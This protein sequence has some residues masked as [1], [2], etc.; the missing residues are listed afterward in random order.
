M[1]V[2]VELVEGV[3]VD[4]EAPRV[5]ADVGQGGL[6]RFLHHVPKGARDQ[7]L[8]APAHAGR[9]D[10][11]DVA[12]ALGPGETD[13]DPGAVGALGDL[14]EELE[15]P[16]IAGDV[17]AADD[18][19]S[20]RALLHQTARDLPADR[21]DLAF[22]VANACLRRVLVDDALNGGV[23]E[24]DVLVRQAVL[25]DLAGQQVPLGDLELVLLRIARQP[26]D[27]HPVPESRRDGVQDVGR[28][29]EE[30][31]GE[32][33][34]HLQVMIRESVVLLGIEHL[35]KRRGRVSA[36]IHP[37]LVD[38]VED[39]DRVLGPGPTQALED[40]S[41]QRADVGSPVP[42]NLGL[43]A[44]ASQRHAR[45]LAPHRPGDG[46]AERGLSHPGRTN[47]AEDRPLQVVLQF[48]DG[49]VLEDALLHVLEIVVV[50][51]EDRPRPGDLDL[52]L[53]R[54]RPGDR[55]EPVQVGAG[56]G[57]FRRAGR[58]LGQPFQLAVGDLLRLLGHPG[59][60]DRLAQLGDLVGTAFVLSQLLLDRLHLLPQVVLPLRLADLVHDL[61]LDL[62]AELRDLDLPGDDLG[63][64]LQPFAEVELDEERHLLRH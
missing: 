53:G 62:A 6:G 38:L 32:I 40:P 9:F 27:F 35:E 56:D 41:R 8:A 64:P 24:D 2:E 10:K 57:V 22:Q 49:E 30:H 18:H 33:E 36:K 34:R 43:V 54:L 50:L 12:S 4:P 17:L 23:V 15:R 63:Q 60:V 37:D 5:G 13:R 19:G 14:T 39:E 1:H 47:E 7:D 59:L 28:R 61:R 46:L 58:H 52:V 25:G 44:D 55:D 48:A 16:E 21:R 29:D 31:L 26:Q 11:E 45:E 51:V 3:L 20:L 42:A